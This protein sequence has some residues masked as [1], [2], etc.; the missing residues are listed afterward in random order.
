MGNQV[1]PGEPYCIHSTQ[2]PKGVIG[3]RLP[4]LLPVQVPVLVL[5]LVLV[6]LLV[7]A[8]VLGRR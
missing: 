1:I 6:P 2:Y 5:V 4:V 7:P 3:G 8:P